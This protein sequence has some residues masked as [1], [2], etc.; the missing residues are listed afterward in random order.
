VAGV[1]EVAT[2]LVGDAGQDGDGKQGA[3]VADLSRGPRGDSGKAIIFGEFSRVARHRHFARRTGLVC[4]GGIQPAGLGHASVDKGRVFFFH[5]A[6][7][8]LRAEIGI[9]RRCFGGEQQTGGLRI[10]PV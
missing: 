8:E 5:G 3:I 6:A 4:Q 10:Q 2:D 9:C 7:A 1:G